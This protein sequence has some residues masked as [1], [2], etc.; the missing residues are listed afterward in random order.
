MVDGG[1]G[2]GKN[3]IDM[4]L[5]YGKNE[6]NWNVL[7]CLKHNDSIILLRKATATA[8][9]ECVCMKFPLNKQAFQQIISNQ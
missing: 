1:D 5:E 3:Q 4:R 8:K 7:F 9:L 6:E 2:G